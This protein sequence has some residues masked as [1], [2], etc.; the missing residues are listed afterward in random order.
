MDG[1]DSKPYIIKAN[2]V[3]HVLQQDGPMKP[4]EYAVVI[5]MVAAKVVE[6]MVEYGEDKQKAIDAICKSVQVMS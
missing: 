4:V 1:N 3:L 6:A 5:G 2:K